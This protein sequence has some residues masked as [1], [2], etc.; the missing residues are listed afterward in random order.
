MYTI[1]N[2]ALGDLGGTVAEEAIGNRFII[3][4][5]D[6]IERLYL[7]R[8]DPELIIFSNDV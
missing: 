7:F 5:S 2:N 8:L 6:R 4:R 1:M 3:N